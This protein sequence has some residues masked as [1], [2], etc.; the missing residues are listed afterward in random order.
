M[1]FHVRAG[2]YS[3]R[4]IQAI[5]VEADSVIPGAACVD[6]V[7]AGC[8]GRLGMRSS[9]VQASRTCD[10]V[11]TQGILVWCAA[12]LSVQWLVWSMR[13]GMQHQVGRRAGQ[14]RGCG[15]VAGWRLR[16]AAAN[17]SFV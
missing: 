11:I 9:C 2:G 1:L 12:R 5:G 6:D 10:G 4:Y 17:V 3:C 15:S 8:D 13:A 16:P 7:V 14:S